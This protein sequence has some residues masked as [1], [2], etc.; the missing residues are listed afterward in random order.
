MMVCCSRG[1]EE[2]HVE[3]RVDMRPV[4]VTGERWHARS[5]GHPN[6]PPFSHGGG[7][8]PVLLCMDDGRLACA[9][10][11]GAP[12]VGCGGEISLSFSD[13][14]GRSWSEYSPV[15]RGDLE[16]SVDRRNHSIGQA[17]NGDLVLVYGLFTDYDWRG[18]RVG[19]DGFLWMES[20]RSS[21]GGETWTEPRRIDCL[22]RLCPSPYGQMRRLSDNTLVFNAR[23][24]YSRSE[25]R[26]NPRLPKRMS[27]LY[28]SNDDGNTWTKRTLIRRGKTEM[29]FL[30]LESGHWVGYV[31]HNRAPSMIAHSYDGGRRWTRWDEVVGA[32]RR[33]KSERIPGS[34]AKLANGMVLLTYG[35]RAEPF[36][37]RALVSR[38][39]GESFDLGREYVIA[40]TYLHRDCGYPSTVCLEDGTVVTA[41]YALED[42]SHPDWGTCCVAN[43]YHQSLFE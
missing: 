33:T 7:F 38:D 41:S 26:R 28:G 11:T 1:F 35:Y 4:V 2:V 5:E 22:P 15:V 32:D 18:Q 27:Y 40:S 3:S 9:M 30:P 43:R 25:Y 37:I 21:D 16:G 39:G 8:F 23:G 29:G 14:G 31:R 24:Y 6:P 13:D 42:R 10:R 19:D 20:V 34:I 17:G 12:H 36:G